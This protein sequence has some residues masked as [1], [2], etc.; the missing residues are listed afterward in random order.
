M[1]YN[2]W[3]KVVLERNLHLKVLELCGLAP[4]RVILGRS[5]K[6]LTSGLVL[7]MHKFIGG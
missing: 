5:N 3:L 2:F 4:M 1:Y 6:Y 7:Y